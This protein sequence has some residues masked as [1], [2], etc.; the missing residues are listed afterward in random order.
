PQ[1][2]L[3]GEIAPTRIVFHEPQ[4]HLLRSADGSFHLGLANEQPG[5]GDWIEGMLRELSRPPNRN[6]P[7][8]Y[9]SEVR[10]IDAA[11]TVDD[12]KLDV[13]WQ[14]QRFDAALRRGGEGFSAASPRAPGGAEGSPATSRWSRSAAATTPSFTAISS[15]RRR[16][17][18]CVPN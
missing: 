17:T 10:V 1:A 16:R 7:F 11:L 13:T 4:L 5:S 3:L 18:G 8:G 12:R 9:L 14:A 15:S 6:G 2:A